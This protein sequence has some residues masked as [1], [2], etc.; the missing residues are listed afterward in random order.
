MWLGAMFSGPMAFDGF[1]FLMVESTW[2][3]VRVI[4]VV[5]RLWSCLIVW[6][7]FL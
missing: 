7:L 1:V 4:G 5:S 2:F 3:V 6:C